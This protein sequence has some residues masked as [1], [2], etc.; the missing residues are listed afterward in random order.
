MGKEYISTID[1]IN[2]KILVVNTDNHLLV[3]N[4]DNKK[5]VS[6]CVEQNSLISNSTPIELLSVIMKLE[7]GTININTLPFGNTLIKMRMD[8]GR[9]LAE[10]A[11]NMTEEEMNKFV[12]SCSDYAKKD[13]GSYADRVNVLDNLNESVIDGALMP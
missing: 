2:N 5:K 3:Y 4:I 8:R 1:K 6:E 11:M 7:P 13:I 12:R 10:Q 9:A